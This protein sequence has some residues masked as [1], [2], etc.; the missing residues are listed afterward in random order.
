MRETTALGAAI[1]AGLA[2]GVWPNLDAVKDMMRA[3]LPRDV[4]TPVPTTTTEHDD[5]AQRGFARW[6]RAV[7]MASGWVVD[8]D[9]D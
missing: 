6:Q 5:S 9:D 4:F 3:H 1:A 7:R 8:G 2:I